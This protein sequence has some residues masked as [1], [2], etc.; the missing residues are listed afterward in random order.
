MKSHFTKIF[1]YHN[2]ANQ[3][4]GN[5]VL[6][7]PNE[8]SL[9]K[10]NH[11]HAANLIWYARIAEMPI[12]T[13]VWEDTFPLDNLLEEFKILNLKYIKIIEECTD[14]NKIISY[15]ARNGILYSDSLQII[16]SH[17]NNHATHHRAQLVISLKS[18]AFY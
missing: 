8:D 3:I 5:L 17:I 14:F 9:K 6:Q 7:N 11:I 2:W 12:D 18:Q 10:L 15:K 13:H 4:I 16:L 1:E